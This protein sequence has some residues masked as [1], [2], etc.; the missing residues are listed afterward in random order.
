MKKKIQT[1]HALK[2]ELK[3]SKCER[4][5]PTQ[6]QTRTKYVKREGK[7]LFENLKNKDE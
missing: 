2:Q 7:S 6:V 5:L 3:E 4:M 1:K